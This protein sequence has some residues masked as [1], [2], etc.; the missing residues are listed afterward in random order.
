[1]ARNFF[2]QPPAG[3]SRFTRNQFGANLGG[4][5]SEN[6]TFFFLSYEGLRQRQGID[7]NSPV[8]RADERAAVTDAVSRRL[9]ALIPEPNTVGSRGEGRFVGSA[10]APVNIDQWTGDLNHLFGASDTLNGLGLNSDGPSGF[11]QGRT[12]TTLVLSDT[13]SYLRGRHSFK[14]GG[15]WRRFEN[16]NFNSDPGDFRFASLADFQAGRGNSFAI[17]LGDR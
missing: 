10:T 9:L 11:P 2:N 14:L 1:D 17:T 3:K 15:E 7:I 12:G 6:K 8:L 5:I 16:S 4:P 13:V